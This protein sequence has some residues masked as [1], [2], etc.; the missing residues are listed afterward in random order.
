MPEGEV[1]AAGKEPWEMT[2]EFDVTETKTAWIETVESVPKYHVD[3]VSSAA[4]FMTKEVGKSPSASGRWSA[5]LLTRETAPYATGGKGNAKFG[6]TNRGEG[7]HDTWAK[8]NKLG[9]VE[10]SADAFNVHN[11]IHEWLHTEK[12]TEKEIQDRAI[13]LTRKFFTEKYLSEGKPVPESVLAQYPDLQSKPKEPWEMNAREFDDAFGGKVDEW[14]DRREEGKITDNQ[15]REVMRLWKKGSALSVLPDIESTSHINRTSANIHKGI[16]RESVLEGKPVPPEVLANYP[17][18][19]KPAESAIPESMT[20]KPGTANISISAKEPPK[21]VGEGKTY[22]RG[23]KTVEGQN[24]L[25]LTPSKRYAAHYSHGKGIVGQ[26][27]A[28][29]QNVLKTDS[30]IGESIHSNIAKVARDKGISFDEEARSR[31]YDA[32]SYFKGNEIYV[33]D[34]NKVKSLPNPTRP[35]EEGGRSYAQNFRTQYDE[36]AAANAPDEAFS[37]LYRGSGETAGMLPQKGESWRQR[38]NRI[39]TDLE[40][41]EAEKVASPKKPEPTAKAAAE[42]VVEPTAAEKK[43][44]ISPKEQKKY[45]LSAIDEALKDAP[46]EVEVAITKGA[47]VDN[48]EYRDSYHYIVEDAGEGKGYNYYQKR[49]DLENTP[50]VKIEIPNDGTFTI[51]NDKA[52]LQE[53]KKKAAKFPVTEKVPNAALPK[54]STA[55]TGRRINTEDVQYYNEFKPRNQA[56]VT[57]SE[58]SGNYYDEKNGWYSNRNYAVKVDKPKGKEFN[59]REINIKN[60]I[61]KATVSAK[62]AGEFSLGYGERGVPMVHVVGP[63]GVEASL[64]ARFVDAILTQYPKAKTFINEKLPN[65]VVFMDGGKPVGLVM[66]IQGVSPRETFADRIA[67]LGV[68]KG[69]RGSIQVM[70]EEWAAKLYELRGDAKAAMPHLEQL[71]RSV[72]ESGANK[73]N[74]W[75]S[76]MKGHLGEAWNAFKGHLT[77]VWKT[78]SKPLLN[79]KGAVGKDINK[80]AE[81][82]PDLDKP[83]EVRNWIDSEKHAIASQVGKALHPG[84]FNPIQNL[85]GSPEF[86]GDPHQQRAVNLFLREKPDMA[87]DIF[88]RNEAIDPSKPIGEDNSVIEV[89]KRLRDKGLTKAQIAKN[90]F[91]APDKRTVS[92][93]YQTLTWL[94]NYGD[95]EY[96]RNPKQTKE[97]QMQSF[98]EDAARGLQERGLSSSQISEVMKTWGHFRRYY[99]AYLEDL[100]KPMMEMLAKIDAAAKAKGVTPDLA[101]LRT[102]IQYLVNQMGEWK[103]FYAPRERMPGKYAIKGSREVDG[104]TEYIREHADWTHSAEKIADRM[105]GEGWKGVRMEEN[106]QTPDAVLQQIKTISLGHVLKQAINAES[107]GKE[108]EEVARLAKLSEGIFEELANIIQSRGYLKTKMSRLDDVH[109][110]GYIED[111]I[112][113]SLVYGRNTSNGL[114]KTYASREAASILSEIN[115]FTEY[116]KYKT[117]SSYVEDNLRNIDR[118]DRTVALLK[119]AATFKYLGGNLRSLLVNAIALPTTAVAAIHQY[120]LDG[121]VGLHKVGIEVGRAAKDYAAFMAGKK[122]ANAEDQRIMEKFRQNHYDDAQYARDVMANLRGAYGQAWSNIVHGS[123]IPFSL[124]EQLNRGATML[125]AYRMARKAGMGEGAAIERARLATGRAHGE[126]GRATNPSLLQGT[127]IAARAG[128]LMYS[129][130]KFAHTYVQM[131]YDL[132]FKKHNIE[133]F[134]WALLSPVV[135]AGAAAFP[136][137]DNISDA[138][139]HILGALGHKDADPKKWYFNKMREWGGKKGEVFARH[140]ALGLAGADV[141]SSLSINLGM[142]TDFTAL[143]G[144]AGG[145]ANDVARAW[146]YLNTPGEK[147]KAAESLLP[148]AAANILRAK[149]EHEEGVTTG[150]GYRLFDEETGQPFKLST[151]QAMLRGAGFRPTEQAMLS[152]HKTEDYETAQQFARDHDRVLEAMRA[153]FAKPEAD[154]KE[155]QRIIEM[156][157][158]YNN[159]V[160]DA[161]K[162]GQ[163][164]IFTRDSLSQQAKNMNM[165]QKREQR[166]MAQYQ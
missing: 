81:T 72:F 54:P 63:G 42:K 82:P 89:A 43:N 120:A 116:N 18:L 17:D 8:S 44:V 117:I 153:Y 119:S 40:R 15:Y 84:E 162:Q 14:L 25:W 74:L 78:I 56:L 23:S 110:K 149:R 4:D 32:M 101:K 46:D 68:G 36:L 166:R 20:K 55:P 65:Q 148:T 100:K 76:T 131:L 11:A 2:K 28:S 155:L 49:I 109:V 125:A 108:A 157:L 133:A 111:P 6:V 144:P 83:E 141:S 64:N 152:E 103:G 142:P 59:D 27:E 151:E 129:Y 57:E 161:G 5:N 114:A 128:Q 113:R 138:V 41:K 115:P 60:A 86:S 53:F 58:K 154:E 159:E 7:I 79:E 132:G 37:H 124:S 91:F 69:E 22:Y 104:K 107:R 156:A 130:S 143:A 139:R 140:G 80:L 35:S 75:L 165:P 26:F 105:R 51:V 99:D 9:F 146:Q 34:K 137:I 13:K 98:T 16:I 122:I 126:Y 118:G 135:L 127:N 61:P 92:K 19:A 94:I 150:K 39:I 95:A 12:G 136:F 29:F 66:P 48:P 121:K 77:Q 1:Q 123:M 10:D 30:K 3:N 73:F 158:K 33:L 112:E 90:A 93:E 50:T 164:P 88:N 102:N 70:P 106:A 85:L 47:L 31:G 145:V 160:I 97:E 52:H 24:G 71:G 87:N 163:I 147:S 134:A 62:I 38:A 45:L 21:A 96:V 67:D